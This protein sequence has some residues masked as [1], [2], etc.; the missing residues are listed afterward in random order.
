MILSQESACCAQ[1]SVDGDTGQTIISGMGELHLDIYVERMRREYKVRMLTLC[2]PCTDPA[3]LRRA[4]VR[5]SSPAQC[6]SS[7]KMRAGWCADVD[8]LW[9]PRLG[10]PAAR[11]PIMIGPRC[12]S[13][14]VPDAC[15]QQSRF[16][17]A[18]ADKS[19][20]I[21]RLR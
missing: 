11:G 16:L 1:V 12:A 8:C 2:R 6:D 17:T 20:F 9:A 3:Q 5:C 18:A 10:A 15:H 13:P 4:A 19:A 14:G 7:S 21:C